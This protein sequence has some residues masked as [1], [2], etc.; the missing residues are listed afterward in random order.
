MFCYV[1]GA[2]RDGF[3]KLVDK[4]G[5]RAVVEYFD[6]PSINGR[7]QR[8]IPAELIVPR[9]LGRNTR[10]YIYYEA[11]NEWRIGR[12]R[13]DDG[14]GVEVRLADK[15]D[16]YLPYDRVFVRWKK[17]IQDPV[18]FLGNFITETPQYA[19]A[20]SDFLKSYIKQRGSAFG[21]PALLSSSIELETHQVGVV[22]RILTDPSQRYLLADEVGLG[23]TIEAG[24]VI[25]QAVLDDLRDHRILVLVPHTLVSQWREELANR[26][27]LREFLDESVLVLPQEESP[28]LHDALAWP[29]LSLIVIDEAHHL[30]DPNASKS[31]QKLY[32]ILSQEVQRAKRLL[33][34]SA[35]PILRN[36]EG[37]LRM[38]HL[39]DSIVYPLDDLE[40]FRSKIANRQALA[41]NVAAI[42]PSNVYF[43]DAALDDLLIRIPND[44]R[45][46]HLT[47][48]LKEHLLELP[49]E[50]DPYFCE[51]VRQLR[52]HI[53]ETYRLNRRILRNRR[54]QIKGLTPD[55]KGALT[56]VAEG[57]S[58][59]ALESSLED[60][61]IAASISIVSDGSEGPSAAEAF[62]WELVRAML[63]SP[64]SLNALC[65]ERQAGIENGLY[66][67][68]SEEPQLLKKLILSINEE[69]WME[70]R[71]DRLCDGLRSLPDEAKVVVFCA[72][73]FC[74]DFVSTQLK[75]RHFRA[76]R[77]ELEDLSDAVFP[78]RWKEFLTNYGVKII[79]CGPSAE[80]GINLQGGKKIVVHFDMPIQPNRIEQRIGRVD[81]YGSGDPVQ[82]YVL[83][84][85]GARLQSEWFAVLDQGFN[86]F[87]RSI[88]SL[89]YL[90]EEELAKLQVGLLH[91]GVE[92]LLALRDRL[93]G[94]EGF[95]AHELK[96]ID[97]QD[98]LDELSAVVESELDEL[99]DADDEW[100]SIRD[101]FLKWIVD[102]LLFHIQSEPHPPNTKMMDEPFRLHYCS[103]DG[104]NKTP[105]LVPSS[106]F[107]DDF[108]GAIDYEAPGS[109]STRPQSY[110]FATHRPTA[111]RRGIRPMRYGSEFVEAIKAFSDVDD[112]GRSYAM[113]R[114][115][116]DE[117]PQSEI[118]ICFRFDFLVEV[119]L[120]EA[121]SVLA[122]YA[123]VI[124][125]QISNKML[126][127]RGDS[128][129]RPSVEQVW[130]D[131]EGE[132]L[133]QEFI[134]SFLS[135]I[136]AKN[137]GKGYIDKNLKMQHLQRFKRV[138][139]D[140]FA[141]WNE[142]CMRL[143]NRALKILMAR[144]E[145]MQRQRSA[146]KR[147]TE[148]DEIRI[149]QLET[150]IQYLQGTEAE[151]ES[152]QLGLEQQLGEALRWG[153][154]NP[155][156][157]V[158]VAGVVFLTSESVSLI[159]KPPQE[160]A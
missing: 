135:P 95:V 84:D 60:W 149:A 42:H 130:V 56:W 11:S 154:D 103:P 22:R 139:P 107:I 25:R 136:Y 134:E 70:S 78:H 45:L 109:R 12:V 76:V 124:S 10:V 106:S 113:W 108:L 133:T 17:P 119:N 26:F 96:L 131:E 90:V 86:V 69:D 94:P 43:M 41:E 132:E 44:T 129:F 49:E 92:T 102:A 57:S 21:I 143:R 110:P 6:F 160:H 138:S 123:D 37:F 34:L 126:V 5:G 18:F 97:Q 104:N 128:L 142:R 74:A 2:K 71:V 54:K 137:G 85:G 105:T 4:E 27:A 29:E 146:M 153:I 81:R 120:D 58:A 7:R 48:T 147:A 33:L 66:P 114:Q 59:I 38:L 47:A 144:D 61:R 127:R 30:A 14:L 13:E 111:V 125:T 55:R 8:E 31:L 83:L 98:A 121:I 39:L 115:V 122:S 116:Y 53:S 67:S 155:S 140:T 141:N 19:E 50:D 36:E 150:R 87:S 52:A 101:A 91:G 75:Q 100:K 63:E 64:K 77:H 62:Y 89:Q 46:R 158:D 9:T 159:D 152:S 3:G 68:F 148:D 23:K 151:K 88:S 20:R 145:M 65:N 51:A 82:S 73:E 35:T 28:E 157:K 15:V 72:T 16:I 117:F 1:R 79:V 40:S 80:E 112:R 99:F 156:V 32:L 118:K 93:A 24:V